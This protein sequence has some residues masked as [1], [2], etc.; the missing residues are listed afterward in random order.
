MEA[1]RYPADYDGIVAGA[2]A[3]PWTHLLTAA[4]FDMQAI[5]DSASYIPATKL[6]AIEAAALAA[7]DTLDGVKDGVIE[8][9]AQCHF[10]PGVLLCKAE[11]TAACLTA[12]QLNALRKIYAGPG[13]AILPGFAPG[14][15]A[16]SGGWGSWISGA[17][18][19]KSAQAGFGEGFFKFMVYGDPAW[20]YK[21]STIDRN[22]KDADSRMASTLNASETNLKPFH[23]RGGKLLLYHGWSDAAIPPASTVNYY[24]SVVQKMG[25][26]D[27]ASFVRLFMAPGVQHCSGG[28]GPSA[29]GQGGAPV[30]DADHDVDAA[31]ERWVEQGK[32]PERIVAT[33]FKTGANPASGIERTRPL[34]SYPQTAHWTGQ[35]SRDDAA[36]FACK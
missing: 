3:Y 28:A 15:E 23:D 8:D 19:G 5:A 36:N 2:P 12:P 20:D 7:C 13:A 4:I 27:A 29:F 10:D 32:A 35:G 24:Q 34:C 18:P 17:T 31:V 25:T 21:T 22:L 9:P 30:N 11:E 1:Q 26:K 33:K 14:G 16:E 6:P